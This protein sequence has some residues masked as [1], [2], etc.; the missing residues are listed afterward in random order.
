MIRGAA[1]RIQFSLW[2]VGFLAIAYC[3]AL[4]LYTRLQQA[5]GNWELDHRLKSNAA[6]AGPVT[7]RPAGGGLIGRLQIPRLQLSAIVFEG[8]DAA[9]LDCGIGHLTGS[10]LPG[11]PGNVVLAGHRDTFFRSLR[12]IRDGD[13]IRLITERGT[14]SYAVESIWV[15]DPSETSVFDSTPAATLTL[16][17]CYPFRYLGR[18]PQRFV[19]RCAARR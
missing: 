5:E 3:A 16:I 15:I 17:T 18:A 4:G 8:T 6:S 14:R 13:V 10:P 9:V 12:N 19:V 2:V 11:E 7:A 1:Q